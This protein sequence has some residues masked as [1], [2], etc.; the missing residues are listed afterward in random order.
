MTLPYPIGACSGGMR[1]SAHEK[2]CNIVVVVVTPT[3]TSGIC[4]ASAHEKV[5]LR[6][7]NTYAPRIRA[8]S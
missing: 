6:C 3:T 1:A 4:Y 7:R 5:C 2:V 8:Y